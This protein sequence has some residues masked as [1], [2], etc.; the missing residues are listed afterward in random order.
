LNKFPLLVKTAA[1]KFDY[2]LR[3]SATSFLETLFEGLR[4]L[5]FAM[6]DS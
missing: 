6:V 5:N 3:F 1:C 2:V 4:Y